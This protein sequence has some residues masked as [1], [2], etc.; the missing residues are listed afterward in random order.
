M[1]SAPHRQTAVALINEAV[2][3][4]AQRVRA[5]GDVADGNQFRTVE[6]AA[7]VIPVV[8]VFLKR[9]AHARLETDQLVSAK[10][11]AL[12]ECEA[13]VAPRSIDGKVKAT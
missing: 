8:T 6:M 4:S 5:G 7:G 2:I 12:F 9:S 3:V 1:I 10:A 13:S 11:N